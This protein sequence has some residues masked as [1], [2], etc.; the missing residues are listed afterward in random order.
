M[1]FRT[2]RVCNHSHFVLSTTEIPAHRHDTTNAT[3]SSMPLPRPINASLQGVYS[4]C[5][6]NVTST[7]RIL[8]KGNEYYRPRLVVVRIAWIGVNTEK[9]T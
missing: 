9:P 1:A 2:N 6:E 7:L 5:V 4:H 8:S 3:N